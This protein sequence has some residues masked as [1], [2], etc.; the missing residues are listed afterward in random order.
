MRGVLGSKSGMA[1]AENEGS[2]LAGKDLTFWG[3]AS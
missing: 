1:Q 3:T 2:S